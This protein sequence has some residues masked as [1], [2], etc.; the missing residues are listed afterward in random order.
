MTKYITDEDGVR[1]D[2]NGFG[3]SGIRNP[4]PETFPPTPPPPPPPP[5]TQNQIREL[6]EIMEMPAK[7]QDAIKEKA[8]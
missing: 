8:E 2:V 7:W 5:Q 6:Q 3:Q 4:L 1:H